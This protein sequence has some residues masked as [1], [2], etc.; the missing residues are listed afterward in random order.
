MIMNRNE[1]NTEIQI[2]A[3][4]QITKLNEL[5]VVVDKVQAK[6]E[7]YRELLDQKKEP[8]YFG[9]AE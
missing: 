6:R 5:P 4:K 3:L 7:A 1:L 2:E 8:T 9:Q